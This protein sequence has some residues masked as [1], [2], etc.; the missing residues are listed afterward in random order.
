MSSQSI[1]AILA[2]AAR[3]ASLVLAGRVGC[4]G[5]LDL[6]PCGFVLGAEWERLQ[7]ASSASGR[8]STFFKKGG[9]FSTGDF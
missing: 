3:P 4:G 8:L 6:A 5:G 1:D 9:K 7:D 2:A